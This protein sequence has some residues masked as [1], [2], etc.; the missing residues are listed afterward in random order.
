MQ[1]PGIHSF[2]QDV[3]M[4]LSH[5]ATHYHKRVPILVGS[6]IIDQIVESLMEEELKSLS[7]SWKLAYISTVL[8]KSL[9]VSDEEFDLDQVKGKVIV[10]KKVIVPAFQMIIVKGLMRVTGH[11]KYV[12][13]LVEPS[14]KCKNIFVP[15]NMTELKPGGSRVDVVLQNLSWRNIIL[16]PHTKVGIVSNVPLILTPDVLEKNVQ[17]DKDKESVQCQSTHAELSKPEIRQVEIDPEEV[18]QKTDLL[19]ATD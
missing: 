8:Y 16:E 10:T 3:L 13:V 6:R 19:G 11:E 2:D 1:I 4:L 15:G 7:Q 18:L 12:H 5:T 9:Q 17:D 14:P